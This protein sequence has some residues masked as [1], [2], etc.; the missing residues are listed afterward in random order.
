MF[1]LLNRKIIYLGIFL[2]YVPCTNLNMFHLIRTVLL[3][4]T[5]CAFLFGSLAV[6]CEIAGPVLVV[7][8]CFVASTKWKIDNKHMVV[9]K[10]YKKLLLKFLFYIITYSYMSLNI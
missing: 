3:F 5:S 4:T 2:T 1:I 8:M 9:F 6:K 7:V 10:S